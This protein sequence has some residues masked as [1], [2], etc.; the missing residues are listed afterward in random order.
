[1]VDINNTRQQTR[2]FRVRLL[3]AAC[4]TLLCFGVLTTRFWWLQVVQHGDYLTQAD[5][6]RISV[7]AIAPRRGEIFDRNGIA[8]ARNVSAWTL[9]ITPAEAGDIRNTIDRLAELI[10]ITEGD[11]RRFFR[12]RNESSRFESIPLRTSLTEQEAAVF[13]AQRFRFPGVDLQSRIQ[14]DC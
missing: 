8:L 1:M 14:R 2:Q 5:R 11:R 7:Q 12:L 6:N 4:F 9:E 10:P 13:A 3:I